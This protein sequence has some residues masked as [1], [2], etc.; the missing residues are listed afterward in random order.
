[1]SLVQGFG[2]A[3]GRDQRKAEAGKKE[4]G[5]EEPGGL[6]SAAARRH[7]RR[8]HQAQDALEGIYSTDNGILCRPRQQCLT[9]YIISSTLDEQAVDTRGLSAL[10]NIAIVD[11]LLL[12]SI[13]AAST[14]L[15]YRSHISTH[16]CYCVQ[17]VV[18]LMR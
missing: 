15:T 11:A 5:A 17:G 10:L 18:K 3:G 8:L 7:A 9:L 2:Q 4:G 1:M 6:Q 13:R 14:K 12:L 16:L